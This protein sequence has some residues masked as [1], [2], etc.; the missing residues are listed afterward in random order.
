MVTL[1]VPS[2]FTIISPQ[3]NP[4]SNPNVKLM[5][6]TI[7]RHSKKTVNFTMCSNLRARG[8]AGTIQRILSQNK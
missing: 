2:T 6:V 5:Y 7:L 4:I 3:P 1:T 8:L